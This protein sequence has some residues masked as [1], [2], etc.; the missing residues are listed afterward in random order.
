MPSRVVAQLHAHN[1]FSVSAWPLTRN[2]D[3]WQRE[4]G[5]IRSGSSL[6]LCLVAMES[7]LWRV[8]SGQIRKSVRAM[9]NAVTFHGHSV[10]TRPPSLV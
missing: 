4:R 10:A 3:S 8:I 7:L 5:L 6:H 2:I 9:H 1:N